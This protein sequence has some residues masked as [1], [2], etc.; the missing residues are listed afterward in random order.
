MAFKVGKEG[1]IERSKEKFGGMFDYSQVKFVNM[2]TKVTLICKKCGNSFDVVP[3]SHLARKGC[4]YCVGL[5]QWDT[6]FFIKKSKELN[7]DRYSYEKTVYVNKRTPVIITCPIHGDFEQ[8]PHNHI[9][10]RQGCPQCGKKYA[11]EWRKNDYQHFVEES[12]KRFGDTYEFPDI[13]ELYENSHSKI[14]IKCKQCGNVFEKIACDHLTSP[15]GGC[16]NC[17]AQQ[18]KA[19]IEIGEFI[20]GLLP[21]EEV[22]FRQRGIISNMELDIFIPSRKLAVEYNGVFWH[23]EANGK[24]KNYHLQKTEACAAKGISLIQIFEDEYILHKEIVCSKLAHFLHVAKLPKVYGRNCKIREISSMEAKAFLEKNHIQG[25]AK[26]SIYLGA[27]CDDE[28]VGAMSFLRNGKENE[29]E[30]NRFASDIK[31]NSCGVGGKLFYYFIKNYS[32]DEVKSFADRRWCFK[33]E[34]LYTKLGFKKEKVLAPDYRY[35]MGGKC[36]RHHKFGFRKSIL[37]KKYGL[38][39]TLTESEMAKAIGANK[40][41]DCGLIKYV[42]K[43]G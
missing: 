38:P 16:L 11:K 21:N 8:N 9:S 25:Y 33:E 32:P 43:K 3:S 30:L 15:H 14:L 37:S 35:L 22:L 40:I 1:F 23:S 10:Q 28:I 6:D 17:Y 41:W 26:A 5:K 24:D 34:N 20:K 13:D 29:W 39:M 12:Q 4:P 36:I 2:S 27:F 31:K 18:S 7:G 19:E 42:W